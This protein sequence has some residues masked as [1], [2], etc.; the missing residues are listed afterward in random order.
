MGQILAWHVILGALFALYKASLL[1]MYGLQKSEM[2][3]ICFFWHVIKTRAWNVLK[4]QQV[5]MGLHCA[6]IN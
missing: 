2:V 1:R 6:I 5:H 3:I 4:V